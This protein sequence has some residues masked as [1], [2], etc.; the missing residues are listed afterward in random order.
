MEVCFVQFSKHWNP[1]L[2]GQKKWGLDLFPWWRVWWRRKSSEKQTREKTV[3]RHFLPL[4]LGMAVMAGAVAAWSGEAPTPWQRGDEE[5]LG[6]GKALI[7]ARVE[8]VRYDQET[9]V[10]E[11]D[12]EVLE[13]ARADRSVPERLTISNRLVRS[14]PA[15]TFQPEA[16]EIYLLCVETPEADDGPWRIPRISKPLPWGYAATRK[17]PGYHA[18]DLAAWLEKNRSGTPEKE[19]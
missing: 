12:V 6:A 7:A 4:G 5:G 8:N 18:G 10:M 11:I 1:V 3:N 16:G 19:D 13:A 9:W 17:L 14:N 2:L 15:V